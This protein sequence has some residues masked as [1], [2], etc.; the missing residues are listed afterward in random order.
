MAAIAH[1]IRIQDVCLSLS[2][3]PMSSM[4]YQDITAPEPLRKTSIPLENPG[5]LASAHRRHLDAKTVF[6]EDPRQSSIPIRKAPKLKMVTLPRSAP[7]WQARISTSCGSLD[8]SS[9]TRGCRLGTLS[10]ISALNT[11]Q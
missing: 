9:G 6:R 3:M 10:L 11:K 2:K 4:Q 8:A 5:L 7:N 1:C